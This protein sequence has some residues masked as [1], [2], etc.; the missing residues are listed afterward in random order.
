MKTDLRARTKNL[1]LIFKVRCARNGSGYMCMCLET[2]RSLV[3]CESSEVFE[4]F[5][6]DIGKSL[7]GAVDVKIS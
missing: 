2:T 6:S 3:R 7:V 5:P 4:N 1:Q